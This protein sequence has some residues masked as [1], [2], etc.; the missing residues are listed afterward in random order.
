VN[1]LEIAAVT[2]DGKMREDGALQ[3]LVDKAI[4]F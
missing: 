4:I 2:K 3:F 1:G